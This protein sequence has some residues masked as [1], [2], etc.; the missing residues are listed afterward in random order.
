[1]AENITGKFV[2]KET[3]SKCS[4]QVTFNMQLDEEEVSVEQILRIN[5]KP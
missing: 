3:T 4:L 1:M 5:N 2:N